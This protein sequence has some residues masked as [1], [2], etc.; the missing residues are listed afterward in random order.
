MRILLLEDNKNLVDLIKESFKDK[1]YVIDVYSDGQKAIDSIFN[2]YDCFVLDINV[3]GID[4]LSILKEIRLLDKETPAI[5][6]SSNIDLEMIE[7]AYLLGCNDY[8]KKP[9]YIYE[10]EKKLELLCYKNSDIYL[11]GNYVFDIRLGQLFDENKNNV[12]LTKKELLLMVLLS[13]NPNKFICFEEIEQHVWEGRLTNNEN[14]RTLIKRIRVKLPS[15]AILSRSGLGY[16]LNLLS[17]K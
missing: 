11:V 13:K 3:P 2:G 6:I 1:Y 14:I 17:S 4:G 15:D 7:K 9:F 8:L 12:K 5:I 16:S 10:L